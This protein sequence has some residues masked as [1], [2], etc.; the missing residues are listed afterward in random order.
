MAPVIALDRVGRLP[1]YRQ[2]YG[3]L[4][5]AIVER[6]L[7]PG[8]R[9]P[10]TRA[11]AVELGVSRIPVVEAFEQLLAEGYC[12]TRTGCGTFVAASL[13][14]GRLPGPGGERALARSGP[15]VGVA[16]GGAV[17]SGAA[18]G[19]APRSAAAGGAP[20][21]ASAGGARGSA[22]AGGAQGSGVRVGVEALGAA[23]DGPPGSGTVGGASAAAGAAP[24]LG[25]EGGLP[26]VPWFRGHGAFRMNH[27]AVERFPM[28]L[29][30]RLVAKHA[31]NP[32]PR[33]LLYGSPL[34]LAEL[35][36]AIAEYLRTARSVRCEAAQIMV[37]SGS[38]QAI[39]I[40]ARV[41]LDPGSAVWVEEPGYDGAHEPLRRV[42]ARLVPVPVDREGLDVAAGMAIEPRAR[43]AYL[44]PS[45]QYPLGFIMTA[46]RRLQ[47]LAWARRSGAWILEDDYDSEY[48]Y[49]HQPIAALQGLDRDARV[50]YIGT[51][52]KVLFPALR[53][54]Y[55]A[56][57]ADLVDRFAA[58]RAAMD[59]CPPSLV[60][61]A[62]ADF[63][64]EGHFAR[65]ARKMRALYAERRGVL[66]AAL[67]QQFGDRLEI[68]GDQAGLHLVA[69]F[70]DGEAVDDGLLAATAARQGLW[71]M[72]LSSCY[73][74]KP[75]RR[76][77]VLGY[78]GTDTRL[79]PEAVRRLRAVCLDQ[80][81]A[82][83]AP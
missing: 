10:S 35:R 53:V 65:H 23:V 48:R 18:V 50:V 28:R 69:A 9:L 51:F 8:Q 37:T 60:Q 12:E 63:L 83:L 38:Q 6:L 77:V 20:G 79:I 30:A 45:H 46:A 57:P 4:R 67:R 61:A 31:R 24:G 76:G 71:V 14:G 43:A 82:A 40:A 5:T 19:G 2:I 17:S 58:V 64:R 52:S 22:A 33:E 39:E 42:G 11:L 16:R 13:P 75:A 15:G 54:G 29:W 26:D 74:G 81:A 44:T 72:P 27:P 34:G 7:R 1:L 49:G 21:S 68:L 66:V 80:P 70:R 55:L 25:A 36:E 3:G 73:L 78:G 59:I 47:A 41:L 56:I 62:L 32:K